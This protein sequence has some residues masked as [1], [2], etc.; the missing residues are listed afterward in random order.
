MFLLAIKL[1]YIFI[2][3]STYKDHE[4]QESSYLVDKRLEVADDNR[5]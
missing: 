1:A 5:D 3:P 2:L 4:L